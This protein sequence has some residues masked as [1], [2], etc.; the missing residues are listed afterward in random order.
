MTM[1]A[2]RLCIFA[3]V[4]LESALAA[5]LYAQTP[6]TAAFTYQGQ[7]KQAGSPLNDTADFRFVLF[8]A[9]SD[10]NQASSIMTVSN[11]DVVDG[12]F[13]VELDFGADVFNG[14][15]RWLL[16]GVRSPAGGGSYTWLSPRQPL[17]AVP[18]ATQTRGIYVDADFNVGVGTTEPSSTLDV[19]GAARTATLEITGGSPVE[20]V[21]VGW[22]RND[23]GQTDVPAGTFTA[24]AGGHLHSLAIR[25]DG[26]LVGWGS[27]SYGQ[28][29]DPAGTFTA[30]AA[31][32]FHSLAIRTD[33]TLVGWG[34]NDD[35]QCDVPAGTFTA[36]AG[37]YAHSLAI[38]CDGTLAGWGWNDSGQ[39][40][41]PAGTFTAI[42]AGSEH[43]LA[44]H[45][46]RT[47]V[48]W[49][50][51]GNGQADVPAGTFMAVA[52]G[53]YHSLAICSDGTLVGW[54]LDNNGQTD[55][56]TGTF[57][58]VAS[59]PYFG[60]AI[61][62]D[63]T[64]GG[65]GL[66]LATDSALKPGTNTWTILS[67]HRLKKN[68]RPLSGALERLLRLRGVTFEWIDPR[69]HRGACGGN[70]GLIAN[71]VE[72]VFPE[73]V[74]RDPQGYR[75]LTIG[76]F[77]ALTAEALRD[78]RAE[79]DAQLE[80]LRAEKDAQISDLTV[81]LERMEAM[82]ARL[83]EQRIGGDE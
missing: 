20:Q 4:T 52:A 73:W 47:L 70:I 30:V 75:T 35:Y 67:D 38:C 44:I 72:S 57:T 6:L 80:K 33:G 36:V 53:D 83:N 21:L 32:R 3:V 54:G 51:N 22:G 64:P 10:G 16:I 61:R 18:Y 66:V 62:P 26:T 23:S 82:M 43:S 40:D 56:P 28:I 48:G 49:G 37:G 14:D 29:D 24:V 79:K 1:N 63:P 15:A 9:E 12:L 65:F 69:S 45:S 78:L 55:V 31:G 71:E 42:A 46:N 50:L 34:W 41:V 5:S 11:V 25:S 59:G 19:N 17:T 58:A 74:G 76:G 81:R 8:D 27:N 68:I 60:L 7:L 39:T 2:G 13:T 77:E